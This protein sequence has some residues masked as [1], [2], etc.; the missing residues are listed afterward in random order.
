[1]TP[2]VQME[3]IQSGPRRWLKVHGHAGYAERGKDI[4][5][6]AASML[7]YTLGQTVSNM[8]TAGQLT[9]VPVLKF[10]SGEAVIGWIPKDEYRELAG[11]AMWVIENGAR[12]LAASFPDY[13][14][15]R[16]VGYAEDGDPI[17]GHL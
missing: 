3:F 15:V 7:A 2:M 1:M 9:E 13:V 6:A 5:C 8:D 4:V 14:R 10:A 12:C 16:T 17:E 11:A